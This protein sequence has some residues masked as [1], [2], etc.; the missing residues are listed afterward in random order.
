MQAFVETTVGYVSA[1]GVI[2]QTRTICKRDEARVDMRGAG[3]AQAPVRR[4]VATKTGGSLINTGVNGNQF[5]YKNDHSITIITVMLSFV[6]RSWMAY[7]TSSS[8][9][10]CKVSG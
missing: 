4:P 3:G 9:I 1:F 10:T 7:F 8:D 2:P 6:P 5:N